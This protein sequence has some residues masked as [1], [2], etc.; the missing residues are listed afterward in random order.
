ML[1]G[2]LGGGGGVS[3]LFEVTTEHIQYWR[4]WVDVSYLFEETKQKLAFHTSKPLALT[5][6]EGED[7]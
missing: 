7:N 3:Y 1:V 4:V 5:V 2:V 6:Y